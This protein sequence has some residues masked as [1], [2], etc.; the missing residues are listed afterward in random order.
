ML[1]WP[2]KTCL[3]SGLT[4][5]YV[6]SNPATWENSMCQLWH[7]FINYL[8]ENMLQIYSD[9]IFAILSNTVVTYVIVFGW[10]NFPFINIFPLMA[11]LSQLITSRIIFQTWLESKHWQPLL[12]NPPHLPKN[13]SDITIKIDPQLYIVVLIT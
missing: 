11:L 5:R 3:P 2:I 7:F 8:I 4:A 13:S 12:T 9:N 6:W 1:F 10:Q